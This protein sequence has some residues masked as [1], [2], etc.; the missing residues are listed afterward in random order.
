[1]TIKLVSE[2]SEQ[3]KGEI[4]EINLPDELRFGSSIS[5]SFILKNIGTAEAKF[6]IVIDP[7]WLP[8]KY[9]AD[10]IVPVGATFTASLGTGLITMPNQDAI[11]KIEAQRLVGAEWIVDDT[12]SH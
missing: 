3:G 7:A 4:T 5:G 8:L 11:I 10:G 2:P 6:K 9:S 1:M 12:K